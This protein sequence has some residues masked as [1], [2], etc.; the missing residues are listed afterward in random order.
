MLPNVLSLDGERR[1]MLSSPHTSMGG[2]APLLRIYNFPYL[3]ANPHRTEHTHGDW[4]VEGRTR[5]Q[6]ALMASAITS[7][8]NVPNNDNPLLQHCVWILSKSHFPPSEAS[9]AAIDIRD[10]PHQQPQ[11]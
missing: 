4:V 9:Y 10:P 7:P 1:M 8:N 6:N 2:F 3:G 5:R 11:H